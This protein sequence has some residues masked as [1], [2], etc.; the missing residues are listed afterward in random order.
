M[1]SNG[2]DS[3][4]YQKQLEQERSAF[5]RELHLDDNETSKAGR[6]PAWSNE[7]CRTFNLSQ[8]QS[9]RSTT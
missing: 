1:E 9:R 7:G 3:I 2:Y 4:D 5:A 6:D 8:W